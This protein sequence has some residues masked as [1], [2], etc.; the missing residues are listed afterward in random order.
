MIQREGPVGFWLELSQAESK[1]QCSV[2]ALGWSDGE[3]LSLH[4]SRSSGLPAWVS[5]VGSSIR[6]IPVPL[7]CRT[8]PTWGISCVH[9]K[10]KDLGLASPPKAVYSHWECCMNHV[11]GMSSWMM[12]RLC[13]Q[14][15][16]CEE[17][18][19]TLLPTWFF[20]STKIDNEVR[21]GIETN[22]LLLIRSSPSSACTK[23][24]HVCVTVQIAL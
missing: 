19:A 8:E 3:H 11:F 17:A 22:L 13:K 9:H 1:V 20:I 4:M 23:S 18:T 6:A 10:H 5:C 16:C 12:W 7:G 14:A 2:P 24:M 21:G 15:S